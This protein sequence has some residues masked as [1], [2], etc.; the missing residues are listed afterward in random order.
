MCGLPGS[1]KSTLS[2]VLSRELGALHWDKD[3]VRD[4][5]FPPPL[6]HDRELND[7]CMELLYAA[8]PAAFDRARPP[9]VIIDGRPFAEHAQRD[10]AARA[11]ADAEAD[12]AFVLCAAPRDV[13]VE[14]IRRGGHP[15]RDRDEALIDR[16]AASWERFRHPVIELDT[17]RLSVDQA[18]SRCLHLLRG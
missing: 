8:L 5:L 11:A 17:S 2:A 4:L 12:V 16:L 9:V 6:P 18:V 14:R 3:A 10:R 13:L 7:R 15:A 1:G